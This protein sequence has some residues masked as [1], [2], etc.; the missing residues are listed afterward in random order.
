[1]LHPLV[2]AKLLKEKL[3]KHDTP[4]YLVN[5]GW[6]G[7]SAT[8]TSKRIDLKLTKHIIDLI[9]DGKLDFTNSVKDKFFNLDIPLDL[10]GIDNDFLIPHK[11][12]N[13]LEEYYKT[14]NMLTNLFNKNFTKF[15]IS[16][17]HVLN[18]GPKIQPGS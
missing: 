8:S 15:D 14:G 16:D 13:N 6:S 12:W 11:G 17:S 9:T 2:Y 10:E 3:V 7:S 1:T 18:S 5:T 4:I